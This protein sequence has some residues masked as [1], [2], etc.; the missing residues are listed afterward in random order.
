MEKLKRIPEASQMITWHLKA[1]RTLKDSR[2]SR[3]AGKLL[4]WYELPVR[5]A[6]RDLRPSC[7]GLWWY[8]LPEKK[9]YRAYSSF[10]YLT[11]CRF[12]GL[13][14]EMEKLSK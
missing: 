13:G 11:D 10:H 6:I 8:L 1:L 9:K 14:A 3:E 5:R 4:H 12:L 2:E 7:F